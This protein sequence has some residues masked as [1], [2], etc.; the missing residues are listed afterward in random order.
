MAR[1]DGSR[2]SLHDSGATSDGATRITLGTARNQ[3]R[4]MCEVFGMA[5]D[6]REGRR[7]HARDAAFYAGMIAREL[8]LNNHEIEHLELAALLHGL[9]KVSLPDDLLHK[10]S[11]YEPQ[12]LERVRNATVAGA[13]WLATVEGLEDVAELVR[14]QGERWDGKGYPEGLAGEMI[15]L[16]AR[17]LGVALRFAAMTRPRSDR[18]ALS[19]VGGALEFL[20]YEAGGAVDP[21]IVRTF[22]SAMGREYSDDA[23][24]PTGA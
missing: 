18:A 20:A 12:E 17:I 16:G 2:Q 9:G 7:G 10:N 6:A 1:G 21:F 14:Y 22:L 15:P 4:E 5:C 8:D 3:L 13:D 23:P 19:V 11:A 24:E